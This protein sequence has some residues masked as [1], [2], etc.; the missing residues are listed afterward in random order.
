[1]L[2]TKLLPL[3]VVTGPGDRLVES[4]VGCLHDDTDVVVADALTIE[5]IERTAKAA[6]AAGG[7]VRWVTIDP[8]PASLAMAQALGIRAQAQVDPILVMSG[9]ATDLTQQQMRQLMTER[10]VVIVRPV[11]SREGVLPN[12]EETATEIVNQVARA[13]SDQ[14]VLFATVLEPDDIQ[15]LTLEEA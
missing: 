6:V 4:I 15:D 8:G 11:Y 12:V 13:R 10:D 2:K 7:G 3:D 1:N 5:H 9:S 14:I